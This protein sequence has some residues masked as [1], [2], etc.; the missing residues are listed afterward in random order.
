MDLGIVVALERE[1]RIVRRVLG[2]LPAGS[3]VTVR[4]SGMG[5]S[6]ARAA[7]HSLVCGGARVLL[8][9]GFAGA[10]D[11]RIAAG[12]LLIPDR[13]RDDT[14]DINH[15]CVLASTLRE[16]LWPIGPLHGG[17]LASVARPVV[18]AAGKRDLGERLGAM[19]VDMESAAIGEVAHDAGVAFVVLRAVS[20]VAD[21]DL[22]RTALEAIDVSG[23]VDGV[24]LARALLRHPGEVLALMRLAVGARRAARSLERALTVAVRVLCDPAAT[25][26]G[27]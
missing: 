20:D 5:G 9:A 2:R 27:P 7:A 17:V 13:V 15:A 8:S 11:T 23:R 1:A 21:L 14:R 26:G 22:P 24:G 16:A 6:C 10:L 25:G 12:D 4:V 3:T 18:S 19:G